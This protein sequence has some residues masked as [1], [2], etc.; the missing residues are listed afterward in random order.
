MA[1]QNIWNAMSTTSFDGR[2]SW[3]LL[4]SAHL[5]QLLWEPRHLGRMLRHQRERFDIEDEPVR[6]SLGP[7]LRV[8]F[9]RQGVVGRIDFNRVELLCV[10]A[11]PLFST[12]HGMR[13][14]QV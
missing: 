7:Q 3:R 6:R 1:L 8:T 4:R 11:Q 2:V 5:T 10:K 12:S 9:R 14:K 13:I